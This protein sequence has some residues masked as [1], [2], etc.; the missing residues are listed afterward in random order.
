MI[1]LDEKYQSYVENPNKGLTIDGA[2][3]RVKGYG[4]TDDG[5]SITGYY[6]MT[7]N[8]KLFYNNDEQFLSM[9]ARRATEVLCDI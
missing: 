1:N 4:Y 9:E 7:D 8:Y 3:E 5:K 2:K 6:V